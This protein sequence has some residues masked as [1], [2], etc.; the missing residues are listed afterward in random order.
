MN[1]KRIICSIM[2]VLL[3]ISGSETVFAGSP[4]VSVDEAVYINL[5]YYGQVSDMSIVKSCNLNGNK[6]FQDFGNYDSV[7]N[8]TNYAKPQLNE[9]SVVWNLEDTSERFYYECKPK[10][11]TI[12]V[13]WTFDVSYKLD[14]VPKKAEELAGAKGLIEINVEAIP[15]DSVSDYYKNNML[16]Q[17][18]TIVNMEDN[19]SLEAPDS[20]LQAVGTYKAV[21]FMALP[22]EHTTFTL[23]IGTESFESPGITM[24]IIPGTMKQLKEIKDLKESKDKIQDAANAVKDSMD[25][26][27]GTMESMSNGL[28]VTR[29]GLNSLEEA[30]NTISSEKGVVY[31]NADKALEDMSKLTD[32]I[33]TLV[34]HIQNGQQMVKDING[35]VNSIVDTINETKSDIK[36]YLESITAIQTDIESLQKLL[37]DINAKEEDRK[38]AFDRLSRNLEKLTDNL[39]KL[40]QDSGNLGR[41][42]DR[43]SDA[44]SELGNMGPEITTISNI[45]GNI[46]INATG[47]DTSVQA[48]VSILN[49]S[50][51]TIKNGSERL[52]S[53]VSN[54][55]L[56]TGTMMEDLE[57]T[58]SYG[59]SISDALRTIIDVGNEYA[60][61]LAAN[62]ENNEDLLE[63][64]NKMGDTVKNT[65]NTA[66]NLIDSISKA[67]D[68]LNKYEE[69]TIALLKDTENL[70]TQMQSTLLNAVN[71][72]NS[73]EAMMKVSGEKLDKGTRETLEGMVDIIGKG[74]EGIT[75]TS[76][77]KNANQ[78]IKDTIDNELD[79][80]EEDN[81]LLN[82]D[83]EHPLMSVTS[84]NNVT[85]D[86]VQILLRTEEIRIDDDDTAQVDLEK[87][88]EK[89]GVLE[90]IGNIF[91][92]IWIAITSIFQ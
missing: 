67:N 12:A 4:T 68:T 64:L 50:M 15:N 13:P 39:D 2:A 85:P 76:N 65:L 25:D 36:Q 74:L 79:H 3:T 41:G 10:E 60:D 46:I 21:V 26:I 35:D 62:H 63:Q 17:M 24:M 40:Q 19:F 42:M 37:E 86:S 44:S 55:S 49:D 57:Q 84:E 8:M 43:L 71:F 66:S 80:Y 54:V 23:R 33:A 72:L 58:M 7:V 28:E 6:S 9:D 61:L 27:I 81:H 56:V 20:Q 32:T 91:K 11:N 1:S 53:S 31:E 38:D 73:L 5:D 45:L 77:I 78:L 70:T 22:G 51:S 48:A 90:R 59:S 75:K 16:L 89:V 30:R 34:P 82:I 47:G 87:A 18:A 52:L 29:A 83:A 88:E 14:G 92:R 69:D